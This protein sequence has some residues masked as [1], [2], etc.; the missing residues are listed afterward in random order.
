M[1]LHR[2]VRVYTYQN[3]TLLEISCTGSI[4]TFLPLFD[5]HVCMN[6][7]IR[8]RICGVHFKGGSRPGD[9]GSGPHPLEKSQVAWGLLRN[10]GTNQQDP[11]SMAKK[12]LSRHPHPR[13]KFNGSA[14]EFSDQI[15]HLRCRFRE[16]RTSVCEIYTKVC[17]LSTGPG[18]SVVNWPDTTLTNFST[19]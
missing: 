1:R 6:Y 19:K 3:A 14:H 15:A 5:I 2:L 12:K 17:A 16:Q 13:T 10:T 4:I 11:L 8:L 7:P 9:I 18:K